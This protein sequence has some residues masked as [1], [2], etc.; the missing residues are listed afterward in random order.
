ML[1]QVPFTRLGFHSHVVGDKRVNSA[2][3][4]LQCG[5]GMECAFTLMQG[6]GLV[7]DCSAPR[8]V[9]KAFLNVSI[10]CDTQKNCSSLIKICIHY[11]LHFLWL[12]VINY[13]LHLQETCRLIFIDNRHSDFRRSIVD[14]RLSE[15]CQ[16]Y[17]GL[18]VVLV[19]VD[20]PRFVQLYKESALEVI[21]S[22]IEPLQGGGLG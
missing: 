20:Y 17:Q 12:Y 13:L 11:K 19:D 7:V 5:R 2:L 4:F 18:S 14:Y 10:Y 3:L 6:F 16:R 15:N 8:C 9:D 22:G 21:S 1:N